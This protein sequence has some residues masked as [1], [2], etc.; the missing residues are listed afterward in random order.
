MANVKQVFDANPASTLQDTDLFYLGR[1]PYGA[2]ND[3]ACE[4][5]TI[6]DAVQAG[7][8]LI[9]STNTQ[10]LSPNMKYVTDNGATLVTYTLPGIA[11]V[12]SIIEIVGKS[13]G[14]FTIAQ[15]GGQTI[16]FG[17]MS[18]TT[19]AGGSLSATG[20]YDSVKLF[21][22]TANTEFSVIGASGNLTVV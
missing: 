12:G 3:M 11:A 17:D 8:T 14:L 10:A 22:I 1:D 21:C 15:N 18:T 2:V 13:S 4:F 6:L 20:R 16:R 9:V 19:G 5:S 7:S